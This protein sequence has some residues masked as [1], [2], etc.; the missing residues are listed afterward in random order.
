MKKLLIVLGSLVAIVLLAAIILPIVF[1]DDIQKAVDKAMAENLN[2]KVYYDIDAF[3]LS[4]LRNFP[5]VT[6]SMQDFGVVNNAPFEGDTLVAVGNFE[7]VVN[8]KSILFDDQPRLSELNLDRPNLYIRV[9]EDGRANY[10]IAVASTDTVEVPVDTASSELSIGIDHWEITNG[11]IIY[12]DL[13]LPMLMVLQNVNHTGSGDFT[14]DEFDMETLTEI[15]NLTVNYD[16]VEYMTDKEVNADITMLM[17][18]TNMKFTFKDNTVAVNNFKM[19]FDGFFAMPGED[20][21]M[22]INYAAK[23]NTFKSLFSLIPGVYQQD[24]NG[25]TADGTVNFSGFIKGIYNDNSMPAFKMELGTQNAMFQYPDLPTAVSNIDVD[26]LVETGAD[27]NLDNTVVNLETFH[28][29]MGNNPVDAK[30]LMRGLDKPYI[31]AMAKAQLDL[32]ELNRMFPMDSLSMKGKFDIDLNAKGTY[33]STTNTIP[34]VNLAMAMQNGFVQSG[35]YPPLESIN[36]TSSVI[37]ESGNLAQTVVRLNDFDMQLAGEPFSANMVLTNLDD[38]TWDMNVDGKVDL[39]QITQIYP[40]EGMELAGIITAKVSSQGK[41]SDVEAENYQA[42]QTSGAME[43]KDFSYVA[44]D[45]PQGFTISNAKG[46]FDPQKITLSNFDGAAGSTDLRMNGYLANY[47]AY[48]FGENETLKGEMALKSGKMNLNEFMTED[49]EAVPEDTAAALEVVEIPKDIDFVFTSNIAEVLYDDLVLNNFKGNLIV[50]DGVL[51]M[52]QL[53]FNTLG[54]QF[55]MNGAYDTRDMQKPA[56]DFNLDITDLAIS[57]AYK[58][59]NTVQALAPIAKDM[60]G[61]FSTDF[62]IAGLLLP[63][64]SPDMNTLDGKGI[65]SIADA[66]VKDSKVVEAITKV[67]K[68]SNTDGITLKDVKVRAEVKN[69]RV[70]VDPFDVNIGNFKTTLAGSNGIDGSID[71]IAKMN[72]PAGAV[73]SAVN[74]AIAQLTGANGAVSSNIILNLNIKGTYDDPKVGLAGAEAGESTTQTAKAA[75][76]AKVQQQ[77]EEIEQEL[78]KQK[79]EAEAKAKAEADRLKK[80]A[81]AKAKA[82]AEK[83]KEQVKEETQEATKEIKEEAK[84]KLKKVFKPPY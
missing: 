30:F 19:G 1:K 60:E 36:F 52:D 43:I 54:G 45:F 31:E 66:A 3:S 26:L 10:D 16:G 73:G 32:G 40:M 64:M 79:A 37:N 9:L 75:V 2:A 17:D 67:S 48:I 81:E 33:D 11:N 49:T 53:G 47:I 14:L 65:L 5:N 82:E 8:L 7:L 80:E 21:E 46:D 55:A 83:L 58:N 18:L 56:F 50:R 39:K 13:T 63:D 28:A 15:K 29:Q 78:Q 70:F 42:L 72:I 69:G 20:M 23:D 57:E 84:K 38:Y 71:Y 12:E 44:E 41:M 4:V 25:L 22:D 77:K 6:V 24:F 61:K 59:F 76:A 68:L 62:Q 34:Q 35:E 51:R 74:N 27:G